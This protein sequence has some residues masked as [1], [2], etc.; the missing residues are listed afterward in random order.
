MDMTARALKDRDLPTQK[1]GQAIRD[2]CER[3][4]AKMIRYWPRLYRS[5]GIGQPC[6]IPSGPRARLT[7]IF[8]HARSS[9]GCFDIFA[10]RKDAVAFAEA[11]RLGRDRVRPSQVHWLASAL[12]VGVPLRS[13]LV[14]EWS[15]HGA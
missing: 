11:K 13:L 6:G 2:A 12:A 5:R 10:W 8:E 14:V 3:G 4:L 15:L 7:T 9:S 1:R